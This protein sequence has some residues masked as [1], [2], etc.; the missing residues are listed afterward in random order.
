MIA[1]PVLRVPLAELTFGIF[2]ER[3][4]QT[5]PCRSRLKLVSW[6]WKSLI[7][8]TRGSCEFSTYT[9]NAHFLINSLPARN[10]FR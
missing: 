7:P 9:F 8:E 2:E 10:T 1:F 3:L 4:T 5:K 6:S